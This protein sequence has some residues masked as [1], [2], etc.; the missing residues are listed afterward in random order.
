MPVFQPVSTFDHEVVMVLAIPMCKIVVA[1]RMMVTLPRKLLLDGARSS[2][3]RH[4]RHDRPVAVSVPKLGGLDGPPPSLARD[5]AA[6]TEVDH[7]DPSQ[8]RAGLEDCGQW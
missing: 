5:G 7:W 1:G 6:P 4:D 3:D 2:G 8:D